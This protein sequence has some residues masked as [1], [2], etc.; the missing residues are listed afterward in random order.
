MQPN[1][2]TWQLNMQ[3]QSAAAHEQA[4]KEACCTSTKASA[5]IGSGAAAAHASL[6]WGAAG[7]AV[8]PSD[9]AMFTIL[10]HANYHDSGIT[11]VV[12]RRERRGRRC[13]AVRQSVT[14]R[15]APHGSNQL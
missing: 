6:A 15:Y 12:S 5:T 4:I 14:R 7:V 9:A 11:A 13:S 1:D 3:K 8:G 10:N 2:F